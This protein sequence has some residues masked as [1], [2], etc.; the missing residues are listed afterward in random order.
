MSVFAA[1]YFASRR[2]G[3]PREPFGA[4][5]LQLL[6]HL[7]LF[8]VPLIVMTV[9]LAQLRSVA[10]AAFYAILT[11]VLLRFVMVFVARMLPQRL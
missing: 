5:P 10:Y 2:L 7:P 3:I 1:V 9:L 6:F 8:V 11:L 4:D